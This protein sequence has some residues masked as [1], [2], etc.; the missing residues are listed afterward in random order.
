MKASKLPVSSLTVFFCWGIATLV[1]SQL[2]EEVMVEVPVNIKEVDA[3]TPAEVLDGGGLIRTRTI[4]QYLEQNSHFYSRE[5]LSL[6]RGISMET[7]TKNGSK[8]K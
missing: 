5:Q 6:V 4:V 7:V 1:N 2:T 3:D 8:V